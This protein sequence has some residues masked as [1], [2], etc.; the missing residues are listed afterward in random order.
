M[1]YTPQIDEAF[2]YLIISILIQ[3]CWQS[4]EIKVIFFRTLFL[5]PNMDL[6]KYIFWMSIDACLCFFKDTGFVGW[7]HIFD[8]NKCIRTTSL[9]KYLQRLLNQISNILLM[10]LVIINTISGVNWKIKSEI[11]MKII[12]KWNSWVTLIVLLVWSNVTYDYYF[13]T[14]WKW[15]EAGDSTERELDLCSLLISLVAATPLMSCTS[16][17]HFS[18]LMPLRK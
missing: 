12:P 6:S 1:K 14:C 11:C 13:W 16:P 7:N 10:S 9:L 8:V 17:L 18:Y 4:N 5:K 3:S 2:I 15:V